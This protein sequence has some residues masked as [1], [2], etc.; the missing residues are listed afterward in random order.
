MN[1]KIENGKSESFR[2]WEAEWREYVDKERR[3]K[4]VYRL[5][6]IVVA[7]AAIC[8]YYIFGLKY[9]CLGLALYAWNMYWYYTGCQ[10]QVIDEYEADGYPQDGLRFMFKSWPWFA[11][12]AVI[13]LYLIK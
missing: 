6:Q 3:C 8:L 13:F 5:T 12:L 4:V 10:S 7:C 2:N 1:H 11:V 9:A